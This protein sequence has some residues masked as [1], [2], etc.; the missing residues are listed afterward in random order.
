MQHPRMFDASKT[1]ILFLSSTRC[2]RIF[3][4]AV[5]PLGI[6][7]AK[8]STATAASGTAT[9]EKDADKVNPVDSCTV[10]FLVNPHTGLTVVSEQKGRL[11]KDRRDD[12]W[13]WV[14]V[15]MF[16][17]FL[18]LLFAS[19]WLIA[20]FRERSVKAVHIK[21]LKDFYK[22]HAPEVSLFTC[23]SPDF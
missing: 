1:R 5:L 23:T 4:Q 20:F 21:W 16:V 11:L 7:A 18:A 12:F 3:S 13:F 15:A 19:P 17:L 22:L 2:R 6:R 9:K 14:Q 10:T 8:P